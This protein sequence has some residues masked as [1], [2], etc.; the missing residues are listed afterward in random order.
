MR[1]LRRVDHFEPMRCNG[2]I[3]LWRKVIDCIQKDES[4]HVYTYLRQQIHEFVADTRMANAEFRRRTI[5]DSIMATEPM[6]FGKDFV[7]TYRSAQGPML[8]FIAD[9][10]E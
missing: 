10:Y 7:V 8:S 3:S 6:R 1:L 9:E 2:H 4:S 5:V